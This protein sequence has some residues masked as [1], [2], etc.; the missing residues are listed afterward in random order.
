MKRED[1]KNILIYYR[2]I[3]GMIDFEK[4]CYKQIEDEYYN[5][6]RSPKADGM[7]HG[8]T[9]G[10]QTEEMGMHAGA[11]NAAREQ[12]K[13]LIRTEVL[14][15]DRETIRGSLDAMN[16]VNKKVLFERYLYGYSWG[17]IS[18][19]LHRPESTVRSWC[20]RALDR[21]GSILEDDVMMLDELT[22]R[23]SRAR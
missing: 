19:R 20:D 23:A 22:A 18:T 3:P 10:S 21:F 2:N 12:E 11:A 17:K 8:Q 13:R 4:K 5:G 16:G 1:V 14:K 15:A 6:I 7:P 9:F